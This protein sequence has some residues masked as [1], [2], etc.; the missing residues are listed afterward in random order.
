MIA[1]DEPQRHP[2]CA[3]NGNSQRLFVAICGQFG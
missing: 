1:Q 2:V 3:G